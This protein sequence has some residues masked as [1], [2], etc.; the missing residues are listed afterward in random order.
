[1]VDRRKLFYLASAIVGGLG[2]LWGE[3]A[4]SASPNQLEVFKSPPEKV[5]VW[6][7]ILMEENQIVSDDYLH[8]EELEVVHSKHE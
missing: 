1:M 7:S 8:G 3:R 2:L 5:W 6:S 4:I